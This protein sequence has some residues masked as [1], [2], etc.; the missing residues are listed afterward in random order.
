MYIGLRLH[1]PYRSLQLLSSSIALLCPGLRW[2]V[3]VPAVVRGHDAGVRE[4]EAVRRGQHQARA[5]GDRHG[6]AEGERDEPRRPAEREPRNL[7]KSTDTPVEAGGWEAKKDKHALDFECSKCSRLSPR[8]FS[9]RL[10]ALA[11]VLL[12]RKSL[13]GERHHVATSA[14]ER[15]GTTRTYFSSASSYPACTPDSTTPRLVSAPAL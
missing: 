6:R 15:A 5:D 4:G 7:A 13:G 9:T 11:R 1:V 2:R 12:A 10:D 3:H 8:G 14:S